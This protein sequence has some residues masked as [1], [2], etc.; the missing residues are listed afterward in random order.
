MCV[1][2]KYLASRCSAI[3]FLEIGWEKISF[4]LQK[5]SWSDFPLSPSAASPYENPV[6]DIP[7]HKFNAFISHNIT[8]NLTL[9]YWARLLMATWSGKM[10]SMAPALKR[11][12]PNDLIESFKIQ[13]LQHHTGIFSAEV[14]PPDSGPFS[15]S[16][17][18]VLITMVAWGQQLLWHIC[19]SDNGTHLTAPNAQGQDYVGVITPE[20]SFAPVTTCW[21]GEKYEPWIN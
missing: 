18:W 8:H 13:F 19:V 3:H 14:Y 17:Q 5:C 10:K 6:K 9:R 21:E 7:W 11:K 16:H 1:F 2:L 12:G 15:G 4:F 20:D